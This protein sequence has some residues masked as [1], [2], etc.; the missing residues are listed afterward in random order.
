ML[1]TRCRYSKTDAERP[2]RSRVDRGIDADQI[3]RGVDE[4]PA[5]IAGIDRRVGLDEVLE[6]IDAE[7]AAPE[8]GYDSH[9]HGLADTEGVADREHHVSHAQRIG[10]A[11]HDRRE[12]N[13]LDLE[14]R[15]VG[16]RVGTD[17]L[18]LEFLAVGERDLYLVGGF[19]DVVIGENVSLGTDDHP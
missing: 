9:G 8:C 7:L 19:D 17:C 10:V 4:R 14:H 15:D 12:R 13:A 6:R 11:E 16:V 3:A 18:R 1:G 5:R 2:A